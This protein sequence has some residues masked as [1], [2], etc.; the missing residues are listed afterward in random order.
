MA[1]VLVVDDE[2]PVLDVVCR[3]LKAR[4]H[5]PVSSA[6]AEGAIEL[7]RRVQPDVA[8]IDLRLGGAVD[9]LALFKLLRGRQPDLIGI[10]LTGFGT[11]HNAL[12]CGEAGFAEYL[13]KPFHGEKLLTAIEGALARLRPAGPISQEHGQSEPPTFDGMVGASP[14]MRALF[15]RIVKVAPL[16]EPA[17]ILGE[18]GTGKEL[19]A[20]SIHQRSPRRGGPFVPVTCPAVPSGLFENELFGHERGAF[21]DARD[22]KPGTFELARGGTVFLDEIGELPLDAQAKLLR[23]IEQHEVTRLGGGRAILIDVRIVAAT[24]VDLEH[25]VSR[26]TFRADLYWRLNAITVRVPAMRDRGDDV[27]RI[28]DHFLGRLRLELARPGVELSGEA[29]QILLAY[30]WPGNVREIEH[31]LRDAILG[32]SGSVVEPQHLPLLRAASTG[33]LPADGS[34]VRDGPT[35][36]HVVAHEVERAERDAIQ[37]TLADC[38][39]N[40]TEAAKRLGIDPRTLYTKIRRYGL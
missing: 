10:M 25:A 11:L 5:R 36:R 4:G 35:L 33:E 30:S 12:E 27:G 19:V 21:T 3:A 32:A 29:R 6:T 39:G 28:V 24:N 9:G 2:R 34:G 17:L 31:V 1:D 15:E 16:Q 20:R 40:Q 13:D 37:R 7:A 8:V 14:P 23:V 22:A 26:H 38:G 18:T